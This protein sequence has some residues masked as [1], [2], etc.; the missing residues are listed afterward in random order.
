MCD[1]AARVVV[2]SRRPRDG[3]DPRPG[4]RGA[5]ASDR[6]SPVLP[7]RCDAA[8]VRTAGTAIGCRPIWPIRS[9]GPVSARLLKDPAAK[10]R[11]EEVARHARASAATLARLFRSETGMTFNQWRT[12]VHRVE[13]I[14]RLARGASV[15]EAAL[16]LGYGSTSRFV[17]MFR[18]NLGVSPG[19]YRLQAGA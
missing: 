16:D 3:W 17:H 11:L 4:L 19:R 9:H 14:E 10:D 7:K 6:Q 15:T 8:L 1:P 18:S 2:D 12:R 13:S 5:G